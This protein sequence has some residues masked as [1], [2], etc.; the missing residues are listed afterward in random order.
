MRLLTTAE[1]EGRQ[2]VAD[3]LNRKL[4]QLD[5]IIAGLT[6]EAKEVEATGPVEVANVT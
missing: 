6:Q 5:R 1:A 4:A 2:R 3:G